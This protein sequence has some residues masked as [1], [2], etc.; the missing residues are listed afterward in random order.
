MRRK[1]TAFLLVGSMSLPSLTGCAALLSRGPSQ[2]DVAVEDPQEHVEVLIEGI[3]NDHQIRRKVPFFTVS[4]DRHSDYTLTVKRRGFQPYETRIGRQAQPHVLGDLMLLGLG[5]YGMSY[6]AQH[7]G[8]TISQLGGVPVMSLGAGLATAG[9]FGLGWGT[10]TGSL[11]R[12]TPSEV[13]VTL[14]EEPR[15]PFWPFW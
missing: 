12:H 13:V 3:S 14:K 4:L 8:A 7:P 2:L 11:W 9:L 1:K 5:T 6:A 15:R 10:V